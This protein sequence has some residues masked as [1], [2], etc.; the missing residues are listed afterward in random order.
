MTVARAGLL[1]RIVDDVARHGLGDRSLRDLASAVG[2][3]HRM[4]LYHFGSRDGLV[5]AIV[6]EV[7]QRQRAFMADGAGGAAV[8]PIA[9][10]RAMWRR[11][12]APE[13]RPF[14]QLFFEAAACASRTNADAADD[15]TQPWIDGGIVGGTS[16]P[17]PVDVRLGVAVARGLLVDVIGGGDL[18]GATAAFERYLRLWEAAT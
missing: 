17:D 14:V 18:E 2:S 7:E 8:D 3:S 15:L 4:L 6:R 16:A 11:V 12:S 10:A 1:D 13:L 5:A 9:V